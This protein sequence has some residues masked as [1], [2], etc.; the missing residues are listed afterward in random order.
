MKKESFDKLQ[1][2]QAVIAKK[3]EIEDQISLV[4]HDLEEH[5]L[6]LNE[7]HKRY[8]ELTE[9]KRKLQKDYEDLKNKKEEAESNRN[10]LEQSVETVT[11]SREFETIQKEIENAMFTEQQARNQMLVK[12]AKLT[13]INEMISKQE[14]T[15][16]AQQDLVTEEEQKLGSVIVDLKDQL[17]DIQKKVD[18]LSLGLSSDLVFKFER[19]IRNQN[20]VGIVPVHKNVCEGCHMVLPIQFVNEIR[21]ED[22]IFFCPYCSRVLYYEYVPGEDEEIKKQ[23]SAR[24]AQIELEDDREESALASAD[25]FDL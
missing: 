22:E 4:P 24:V 9:N 14:I 7:M 11:L 16:K 21:K 8:L 2:L 13:E 12:D 23:A 3:Y 18:E 6:V 5:K 25:E 20:N 1:R 15:V 10:R 17:A 19:I